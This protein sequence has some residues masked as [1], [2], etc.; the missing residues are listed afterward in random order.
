MMTRIAK[1]C[2][3]IRL[4]L[5]TEQRYRSLCYGINVNCG[6]VAGMAG[7]RRTGIWGLEDES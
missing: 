2:R 7:S 1:N 3:R 5:K 4:N 6:C